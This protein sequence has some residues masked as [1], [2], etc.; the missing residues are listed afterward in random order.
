M[1]EKQVLDFISNA[2]AKGYKDQEIK[3]VLEKKGWSNAQISDAFNS[4][5]QKSEAVSVVQKEKN[6]T[7]LI[8]L[9]ALFLLVIIGLALTFLIPSG[10]EGCKTNADCQTGETCVRGNC[11][12]ITTPECTRDAEC[13]TGESCVSGK[14][15]QEEQPECIFDVDCPKGLECNSNSCQE[16]SGYCEKDS[17][18]PSGYACID[19]RCSIPPASEE[20][21]SPLKENYKLLSPT[22][23]SLNKTTGAFN[24][25]IDHIG[26]NTTAEVTMRC[27]LQYLS[28]TT[29]MEQT[30]IAIN[31]TG[32]QSTVCS[33]AVADIYHN[34]STTSS[35]PITLIAEID[36]SNVIDEKDEEDN[37]ASFTGTW[38]FSSFGGC[39]TTGDCTELYGNS[40]QCTSGACELVTTVSSC[41]SDSECTS[42]EVCLGSMCVDPATIACTAD[43]GCPSLYACSTIGFC[44]ADTD[45]D[46][47]VDSE[48][49]AGTTSA[50]TANSDC[51]TGQ[52][53]VSGTCTAG[54]IV[55]A[56]TEEIG[57]SSGYVCSSNACIADS[58][59]DEVPDSE[60]TECTDGENNDDDLLVDVYGACLNKD[61][62]FVNCYG[63]G[64]TSVN[65]CKDYCTSIGKTFIGND[66]DCK[67]PDDSESSDTSESSCSTADDCGTG[68][69]CYKGTCQNY[70]CVEDADCS[71]G[72]YCSSGLCTQTECNDGTDNDGDAGWDYAGACESNS[73]GS[74]ITCTELGAST[75]AD[76][77]KDCEALDHYSYNSADA[78]C[79][80]IEDNYELSLNQFECSDG[81]DNDEDGFVDMFGGCTTFPFVLNGVTGLSVYTSSS[82]ECNDAEDN[83]GDGLVDVYGVCIKTE[84]ST[85]THSFQETSIPCSDFGATSAEECVFFCKA[86]FSSLSSPATYSYQEGDPDCSSEE[87]NLEKSL[88][89]SLM[90]TGTHQ[91][92]YTAFSCRDLGATNA[93]DCESA[94][95]N[96]ASDNVRANYL[97][98]DPNCSSEE[99]DSEKQLSVRSGTFVPSM[100]P[101]LAQSII[102]KI[103]R[104]LFFGKDI[105][106]F[107]K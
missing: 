35:I 1:V 96:K 99:D 100:A 29:Q 58:D 69:Y 97:E 91:L 55:L 95:H 24:V 25:S 70:E 28:N 102:S 89:K 6:R 42:P 13:S 78:D 64:A 86:P 7:V 15:E 67:S 33:I 51:S 27:K 107:F 39:T 16:I 90:I 62:T 56:C 65:E 14:C 43:S 5:Q 21:T 73:D 36:P 83:D 71:T 63:A 38:T 32:I 30:L 22:L 48:E 11:T 87:D 3:A 93:V 101:E 79:D 26:K 53:C 103:I 19:N 75:A 76:C 9:G 37:N 84:Y 59:G 61:K 74:I 52:T 18:C 10:E 12:I 49:A 98:S 66:G 23:L 94:C 20:V 105:S 106:S 50:C 72:Q 82:T 44:G 77:E 88:M 40:Y 46:G 41:T 85:F 45:S 104:F 34:L 54:V 47:T 4:I 8:I 81:I 92:A 2:R 80:S 57:C 31:S 17:S 60:E 68:R